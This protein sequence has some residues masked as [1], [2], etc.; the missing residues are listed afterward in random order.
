[1]KKNII[2]IFLALG[3]IISMLPTTAFAV[4]FS[5]CGDNLMWGLDDDTGTLII[6]G[7]GEMEAYEAFETPWYYLRSDIESIVVEEGV[8]SIS[9]NAFLN[10]FLA[11]S[12]ELPSTLTSIPN[13]AFEQ[14]LSLT[15]I[16]I[17]NAVTSIGDRAFYGCE[18]LTSVTIPNNVTSIGVE[19]FSCCKYLTDVILSNSLVS[20]EADAFSYCQV[21]D[22][23]VIPNGVTSIG[24]YAFYY[25][26]SMTSVTI[27]ASVEFIG[28][29]AFSNAGSLNSSLLKPTLKVIFEGDA[30]SVKS[31]IIA[32]T[33]ASLYYPEDNA[34]WNED[35]M[36]N[37]GSGSGISW[38]PYSSDTSDGDSGDT[39][40]DDSDST[41][42]SACAL[43]ELTNLDY[44]AFSALAYEQ[45]DAYPSEWTVKDIIG[46]KWDSLWNSETDYLN[47][48][49][50]GGISGWQLLRID[51][52]SDGYFAA[53][54][55]NGAGEAVIAYRGSTTPDKIFTGDNDAVGDWLYNDLP[56]LLM[57]WIG[58]QFPQAISTYIYTAEKDDISAIAATGHSLGGAWADAISALF[59]CKGVSMNAVPILDV[60][61]DELPEIY[62]PGFSGI[63][64]WN[65][66]DHANVA[67]IW[68]GMNE[69]Y[70]SSA[71]IKPYISHKN[72]YSGSNLFT[73][74][75]LWPL[76]ARSSNGTVTLSERLFQSIP[77]EATIQQR[78]LSYVILG[79]D[80]S[81]TL[82]AGLASIKVQTAYGGDG[83]DSINTNIW[84]DLIVG[85]ADYDNLDGG[86]GDDTYYYFKGDGADFI[87]D[88]GGDDKLYLC[89][90]D[91]E[92]SFE[93]FEDTDTDYI[94]II[95][96]GD[97]IIRI[98]K[99]N[100]EY[101]AITLN[102]FKIIFE[103]GGETETY[104]ITNA[105]YKY[106]FGSH[107]YIGCPVDVQILNEAGD[108]VYTLKDGEIGNHYTDYGNFYV[109]E[110]E[111]GGYGKVLDLIE[112]YSANVIGVGSG[113]MDI[114]YFKVTDGQLEEEQTI[115]RIPV[116]DTFT[117][118]VTEKEDGTLWLI[119]NRTGDFTGDAKVND[120]DVAYLLWHTLF[121]EN[122]PISGNA[123]FNGDSVTNDADVAYLLWHTLFPENYPLR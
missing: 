112:G 40:D 102:S 38:K 4:D 47:S 85:G 111:A 75:S 60:V 30:P 79:S 51:H 74:H 116:T 17:P 69:Q 89:D 122:Y 105:F 14:C 36:R 8:T 43:N 2:S 92:D 77:T 54:F 82:A 123:D 70:F 68:A 113:T 56:M 97:T 108:V 95:C 115:T 106:S 21:L 88:I 37:L 83:S 28:E 58:S 12:V 34:T 120:E 76:L 73:P 41:E 13:G 107:L 15:E 91:A 117:A 118:S 67:D 22:E 53:V 87:Y 50:Y 64:N 39:P 98:S 86:R 65:F 31:T 24:E 110:E 57:G 35:V 109:F 32:N 81:D 90:F 71:A 23:I 96:N 100:R 1:M 5:P 94:E 45:L 55:T 59:G 104:D 61:F 84:G 20:I 99:K 121:P 19:A 93:V 63:N 26:R 16:A 6:S 7:T 62:G 3:L 80:K 18:K 66:I 25:C 114:T 52:G 42:D 119:S 10:C 49:I 78:K 103:R 48:E 27:P 46:D 9:E 72:M 11:T 29:H 101:S 44:L 33:S